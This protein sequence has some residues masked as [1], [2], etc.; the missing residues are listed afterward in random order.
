PRESADVGRA[1]ARPMW[2]APAPEPQRGAQ[3]PTP[4]F[5]TAQ[6]PG[7]LPPLIADSPF[8]T[9]RSSKLSA[10]TSQGRPPASNPREPSR[11][12]ASGARADGGGP[13]GGHARNGSLLGGACFR[14]KLEALSATHDLEVAGLRDEV[15][16]LQDLI[17]QYRSLLEK[18]PYTAGDGPAGSDPIHEMAGEMLSGC[19]G[20]DAP[21]GASRTSQV[22]HA[23]PRSASSEHASAEPVRT[24][25]MTE[26]QQDT[27]AL[28]VT[29]ESQAAAAMSPAA[30]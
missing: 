5:E 15:S 25:F 12:P 29:I 4:T 6:P 3:V 24:R 22:E 11:V 9:P 30:G 27:S 17:V 23:A 2:G 1:P 26:R 28:Q 16:G 21:I 13:R 14:D 18:V 8:E 7:S 10:A 19:F 20:K